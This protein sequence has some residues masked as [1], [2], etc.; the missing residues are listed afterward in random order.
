MRR[1]VVHADGMTVGVLHEGDDIWRFVYDERW[2]TEPQAFD[3]APGLPRTRAEHV[4]GG[5]QRPV[6]WFFDNLLPEERLRDA[7]S[8]EAGIRGEDAFALLEYLGAESAGALTLLP[9]D[10]PL[11]EGQRLRPLDDAI[12]SARI[13]ALPRETLG[14]RAPKRMSLAG[15]QHK[16]L[17]VL[18]GDRLYEPMG[19]TPSTHI[20][21]P[22]HPQVD[23]YPA[24]VAN[25]FLTMRMA[26][27]AGLDPPA[28]HVR[29]VPQPVYLVERFDR[30]VTRRG[31]NEDGTPRLDVR[32]RHVIDACQLLG[33]PRGFKHSGASLAALSALVEAST[34][35]LDTRI[36][37][38][39]WLAFNVL[40]GN[41]DCHLKNLS[42]FAQAEGIRLAPPYD[43]LATSAYATRALAEERG[44]WPVV[45]L[46][47]A[48]PGA[49]HF[50]DVTRGAML[51][52]ADALG[53]PARTAARELDAMRARVPGALD[54]AMAE[55]A[56]RHA[57]LGE[58]GRGVAGAEMRLAR[59]VRDVVLHDM[60]ARLAA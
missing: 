20:L 57:R 26:H 25:E 47:I 18:D 38:Y 45:P 37:L 11:P 8:R 40:V 36:R 53:V 24:S 41:D 14:A 58:A 15:A 21:K 51:A 32:R 6:Q 52:A 33:K 30:A 34:N 31:E 29:D 2:R 60:L 39:R 59:T 42:F 4:D 43:L 19:A 28:V 13:Q 48:V 44:T 12:L 35:R 5:T 16:A 9:P 23:L 49:T 22:A 54:A 46:A 55:L 27:A 1:L 56:A 17:V 50:A 7:V 10:V 3:L